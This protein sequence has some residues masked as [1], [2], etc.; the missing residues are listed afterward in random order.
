LF[1]DAPCAWLSLLRLIV[2]NPDGPVLSRL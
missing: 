2:D 1:I